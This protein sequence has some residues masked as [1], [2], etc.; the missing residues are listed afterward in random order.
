MTEFIQQATKVSGNVAIFSD[1]KSYSY[2]DLLKSS[3]QFATILLNGKPDLSEAPVCFMVNPGFDYVKI[4][5]AIWRA[6]GVAV[7]LCLSHPLPSLQYVIEDT[8]TSII[9]VSPEYESILK[10]YVE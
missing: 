7:P 6:G 4:Q 9:V 1:G 8:G 3:G 2:D 5:W 10:K